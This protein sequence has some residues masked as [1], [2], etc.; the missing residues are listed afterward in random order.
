LPR[1]LFK[2]NGKQN[3]PSRKQGFFG[4]LDLELS[5]TLSVGSASKVS[6]ATFFSKKVASLSNK[7][8]MKIANIEIPGRLTL[9]PMAA[10]TSW[11]YRRICRRFGAALVTTEVAKAREIVRGIEATRKLFSFREDEHPIA[12]QFMAAEPEEARRAVE[13][14]CEA[15]LDL[16]DLNCGCPNRRLLGDGMG[17]ALAESPETVER[18]AAEMVRRADRPVTIKIRAGFR[19][20]QVTAIETARRAESVGV[21]AVCLH[22]RFAQGAAQRPPDWDLIRQVKQAVAIPVIGNGGI[23][24]PQDVVKM[25]NETGC[26]AVAIGQAA[27]GRP[28]IFRQANSLLETGEDGPPPTQQ[29]VLD[30]LLEH[31]RGLVE[32]HGERGGSIMMRKQSCHY[33]KYL[34]NGKAFNRA[35]THISTKDEFLAA[36]EEHLVRA[37]Q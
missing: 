24:T 23:H 5:Q 29:E 27:I 30:I 11:P 15:G 7:S 26:D 12:G 1:F 8:T 21:A 6:L 19:V 34:I 4:R 3:G 36:V 13:A 10:Y 25:F 14:L 18:I 37:V 20:G 9:A 35:C 31:Y 32:L 2:E 33:A 22:P 17:G 28:W 16:I